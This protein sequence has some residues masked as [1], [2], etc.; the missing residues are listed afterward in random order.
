MLSKTLSPSVI[1]KNPA[2][3]SKAFLPNFDTFK[4]FKY[5]ID[6]FFP[7]LWNL[8]EISRRENGLRAESLI[9]CTFN[10]PKSSHHPFYIYLCQFEGGGRRNM[11]Y[12]QRIQFREHT[13]WVPD[14]KLMLL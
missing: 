2:H 4:E 7:T 13:K 11:P 12:E 10:I 3:C 8:E 5:Q 14:L 1:L 6:K 9:R